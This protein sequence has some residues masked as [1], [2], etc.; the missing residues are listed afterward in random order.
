MNHPVGRRRSL[1][2]VKENI[3]T[4]SFDININFV[5]CAFCIL[6]LA[7]KTKSVSAY[8][9]RDDDKFIPSSPY[10]ESNKEEKHKRVDQNSLITFDSMVC[11]ED[12]IT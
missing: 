10:V 1:P 2:S 5:V 8:E 7:V 6:A 3:L 4:T 9:P 12:I 11:C